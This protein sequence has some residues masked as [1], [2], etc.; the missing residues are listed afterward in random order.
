MIREVHTGR[1][2]KDLQDAEPIAAEQ[3]DSFL[4]PLDV[5]LEDS[6][7]N[8]SGKALK[9]YVG[10][11]QLTDMQRA[12]LAIL[13]VDENGNLKSS[14]NFYSDGWISQIG[15]ASGEGSGGGGTLYHDLLEHTDW[16]DLHPIGAI[17]GLQSA[18]DGKA[19]VGHL[20][21][22]ASLTEKPTTLDGFGITDAVSAG[23]FGDH[24][25]AF[26]THLS[27]GVHLTASQRSVLAK[28]SVDGDGNLKAEGNLYASG[29]LSQA[30]PATGGGSGGGGTAYHDQLLNLDYPDQHPI[31]A[32]AGLQSALDAK[33]A[34]SHTHAWGAITGKPGWITDDAPA[35]DGYLPLAGGILTGDLRIE[36]YDGAFMA[37]RT[38]GVSYLNNYAS[39]NSLR[40]QL[41]LWDDG[42]ITAWTAASQQYNDIWHSGNDGSGSGLDADLLDGYHLADLQGNF[43]QTVDASG[44]SEDYYYPVIINVSPSERLRISVIV[45][46]DSGTVP[47]WSTHGAGFSC[48]YI[49]EVSGFGWGIT[50][51]DRLILNNT[52]RWATWPPIGK[53]MQMGNSSNEVIFVRGG[54]RYYFY[55]SAPKIPV[56]ATSTWTSGGE[57]VAPIAVSSFVPD[58]WSSAECGIGTGYLYSGYARI[59]ST[60]QIEPGV[61]GNYTEGLRVAC[62]DSGWSIVALG[63]AQGA[64]EGTVAG[65]WLIARDYEGNLRICCGDSNNIMMRLDQAGNVFVKGTITQLA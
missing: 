49:E 33:A 58:L 35:F 65:Q 39:G 52:W 6:T 42:R 51:I 41:G 3:F 64:T 19:A 30:G 1:R 45:S 50:Y 26:N 63:C 11:L 12:V 57:S 23:A 54:G 47:G 46:L 37:G 56:L 22:W 38:T 28:L 32:V 8:L 5:P 25:T 43:R 10:E 2:I 55:I 29:W 13:S 34:A 16:P 15:P 61:Q 18:L 48:R 59:G 7:C 4:F 21:T 40:A 24:L 53:V 60:L 44:L 36:K 17:T 27:S 31:A 14:A 20:H 9:R 62:A